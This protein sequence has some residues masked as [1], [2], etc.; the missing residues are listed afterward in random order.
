VVGP[1]A[2]CTIVE[3][4]SGAGSYFT[5]AVTEIVAG[6]G[7]VVDHYKVQLESPA[8]F[9]VGVMFASLAAAPISPPPASRSAAP[10]SATKSAPFFRKARTP[11]SMA[12]TW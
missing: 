2:H 5:N 6:S 4:Y 7:S 11:R 10:W 9:H 8:A 1:D 12:S 3:T